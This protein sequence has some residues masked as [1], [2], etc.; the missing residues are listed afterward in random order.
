MPTVDLHFHEQRTFLFVTPPKQIELKTDTQFP[1]TILIED[2]SRIVYESPALLTKDSSVIRT[3]KE[4]FEWGRPS[5]MWYSICLK[6]T[7][8]KQPAEEP[9]GVQ[10]TYTF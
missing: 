1:V 8:P 9:Y 5:G 4:I 10:M 3:P 6:A 2:T 7:T